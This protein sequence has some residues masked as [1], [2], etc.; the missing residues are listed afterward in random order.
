MGAKRRGGVLLHSQA[1][2][3]KKM[4]GHPTLRKI[5]KYRVLY[6]FILPC[7]VLFV[8]FSYAPLFGLAMVFQQYDPVSGILNSPWV[9][10]DNFVAIFNAPTFMRAMR[11]TLVISALRLLFTFPLPIL[12]ALFLNELRNAK[13]KK[14][15]QTISYLPNFVSWVIVAG[16]WYSMLAAETGVVNNI[17]LKLGLIKESIYFMQSKPLFY[18]MIILTDIWKNL[19]FSSILYL[20]SIASIDVEQ[21]EAA[22][23]DGAGKL[24]QAIHITLPGMKNTII[25]LLIM[26]FAGILNAGFDQLWTMGNIAVREVGDILDTAVL[27]TLTAG[28]I[29]DLSLGATMGLFKSVVG[30]VLFAAANLISRRFGQESLI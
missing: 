18:P 25:L 30:F 5:W 9:G 8:V 14:T 19:G 15:I 27:R 16:I 20:S 24:R 6:L 11:N 22:C 10:F 28:T 23:V 4:N 21:Y 17:L 26:A 29:R 3:T 7:F 12:F 2:N 13:F 1:I